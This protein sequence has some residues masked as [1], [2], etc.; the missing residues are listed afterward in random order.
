MKNVLRLGKV[1]YDHTGHKVNAVDIEWEL[2]PD[3]RFSAS[4]AIWDGRHYDNIAGGQILEEIARLFPRDE[5]VQRIIRVWRVWHL[6]DL[7]AGTPRQEAAIAQW[8][9][10]GNKYDYGKAVE[11]LK[12]IGLYEDDGYKYGHAWLKRELPDDVKKEIKSWSK[13]P[14]G[15]LGSASKP[16]RRPQTGRSKSKK[17]SPRLSV[18][19]LR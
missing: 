6:N 10:E 19:G 5:R 16:R 14:Q 2:T 3:G 18:R 1:D 13:F 4:G 8:K 15:S 17:S 7:T 9:A 11:Y 12:S